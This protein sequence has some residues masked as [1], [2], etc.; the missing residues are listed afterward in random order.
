MSPVG[1]W[2][3]GGCFLEVVEEEEPGSWILL[4]ASSVCDQ[5]RPCGVDYLYRR[6]F[7]CCSDL[8]ELGGRVPYYGAQSRMA[9]SGGVIGGLDV[10]WGIRLD[11]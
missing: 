8:G 11:G 1:W 2:L 5:E 7:R 3:I 6:L 9:G 10:L 4:I